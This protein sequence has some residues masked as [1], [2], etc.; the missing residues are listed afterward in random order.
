[1]QMRTAGGRTDER[2]SMS[3][4]SQQAGGDAP[5]TTGEGPVDRAGVS[6]EEVTRAMAVSSVDDETRTHTD[7]DETDTVVTGAGELRHVEDSSAGS[8]GAGSGTPE[9]GAAGTSG[10][11]GA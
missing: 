1:M 8:T 10:G 6:A 2:T 5:R 4:S 11:S 7:A 3:E 9:G